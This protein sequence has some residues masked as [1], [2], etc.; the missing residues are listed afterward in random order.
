MKLSV[1]S[2]KEKRQLRAVYEQSLSEMLKV[3]KFYTANS[4]RTLF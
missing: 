1:Q 3:N 2:V 4:R